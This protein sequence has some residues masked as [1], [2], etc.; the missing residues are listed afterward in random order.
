MKTVYCEQCNQPF[1]VKPY[2]VNTAKFCSYA[3][4]DKGYLGRVAQSISPSK[5]KTTLV[6]PYCQISFTRHASR[7]QHGRGKYCSPACQ[8]AAAKARPKIN[9]VSLICLQ[10]R[11][12]FSAPRS[13]VMQHKGGGK[14]CSRLCRDLHRAGT[15]HPQYLTGSAQEKRGPN[16]QAQRRK[17]L[18]RDK[19]VCQH[20]GEKGT[21][22]HHIIPFRLFGIVRYIEAN[23]LANLITLCETCHRK[24]DAEIQRAECVS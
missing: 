24:A 21:A 9:H 23:R 22:V 7:L 20:C 19:R 5:P 3:C 15:N 17:A 13:R 1:L 8:Y 4:R 6:C 16:W 11:E 14:Y 18:Y 12:A 2:R 10:C